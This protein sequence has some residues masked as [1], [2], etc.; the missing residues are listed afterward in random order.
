MH[1]IENRIVIM[2]K[3]TDED[4]KPT[5]SINIVETG[6]KAEPKEPLVLEFTSLIEKSDLTNSLLRKAALQEKKIVLFEHKTEVF[7]QFQDYPQHW[8]KQIVTNV[9]ELSQ[10]LKSE[11]YDY[12][13]FVLDSN[14]KG[15]NQL[16]AQVK[17]FFPLVKIVLFASRLDEKKV[18]IHRSSPAGAHFYFI[19]PISPQQIEELG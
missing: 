12:V 10:V 15:I 7:K 11:A 8:S 14:P 6:F 16:M 4:D 17:K 18:Q 5:V 1:L 2:T 13:F 9:K 19:L 3:K